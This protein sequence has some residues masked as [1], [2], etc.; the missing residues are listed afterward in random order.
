[1]PA[2]DRNTKRFGLLRISARQRRHGTLLAGGFE[3]TERILSAPQEQYTRDLLAAIP[4]PRFEGARKQGNT[5]AGQ[6]GENAQIAP[7]PQGG[8]SDRRT[9]DVVDE[10][11][12]GRQAEIQEGAGVRPARW[13]RGI[14]RAR[15]GA[16]GRAA[17]ACGHQSQSGSEPAAG[18]FCRRIR[19]AGRKRAGAGIHGLRMTCWI[20]AMKPINVGR[21]RRFT[22]SPRRGKGGV[23]G[24]TMIP[25]RTGGA[26]S[27]HLL[28][29][30]EKE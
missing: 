9:K 6:Y 5:E 22:P 11:Q 7:E 13:F 8:A 2:R 20:D 18:G 25:Y 26:P 19:L 30:G 24:V 4:R 17:M 3:G 28:P 23:R 29:H 12:A 16:S 14:S 21:A 27:S 1:M 10:P 15:A